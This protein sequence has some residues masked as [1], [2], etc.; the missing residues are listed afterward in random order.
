MDFAAT[1]TRI[2]CQRNAL[3]E[4]R[5][6]NQAEATSMGGSVRAARRAG[7]LIESSRTLRGALG[8]C[9]VAAAFAIVPAL[10]ADASA[11]VWTD[12][13]H[14]SPG[15]TV[16]ISG[17]NSDAAGYTADEAVEVLVA[18]PDGSSTSCSA[19]ADEAGAWSC[20][21]TLASD[22]SAIGDYTYTATGQSS[23]VSQ[24]G[25]FSDA[26]CP[27]DSALGN[28]K[29]DPNVAASYMTSGGTAKYS[30]TTPNE[31]SVGGIPGLIE[32]CVYTS[33]LPGSSAVEYTTNI[34]GAWKT[35]GGKGFFAFARSDGNPDNVPFDGNTQAIGNATWTGGIPTEQTIVLHIN[36]TAE[37][38]ALYGGTVETCF[39][40]PGPGIVKASGLTA[41]V[42][43]DPSFTRTYKWE[44]EKSAEMTEIDNAGSA[45]FHYTV[46]VSHD[47]GTDGKWQYS[48]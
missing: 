23:G 48:G 33:P 44:I 41:K 5:M 43:A 27:S 37:C 15:S 7:S 18:R 20:Q 39:V 29:E 42:T 47:A 8:A 30:V 4:T 21:I 14:Y 34:D 40:T 17:D 26:G 10:S 24:S 45:T 2:R 16:T 35:E 6:G 11:A 46:N 1:E 22:A 12:Q 9:L 13:P 36:D 28:Q 31:S 19:T 3:K 32:Y 25:S 38:S